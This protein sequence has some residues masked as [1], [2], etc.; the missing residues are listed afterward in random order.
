[1]PVLRPLP[2]S[3][4]TDERCVREVARWE[5]ILCPCLAS[6]ALINASYH[7]S[8]SRRERQDCRRWRPASARGRH[9]FP[10]APG[11]EMSGL[12]D[13]SRARGTFLFPSVP[14]HSLW[15]Q[16]SAN[17][18]LGPHGLATASDS[19][20]HGFVNGFTGF[21]G[22][23]FCHVFGH[24]RNPGPLFSITSWLSSSKQPLVFVLHFRGHRSAPS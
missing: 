11:A 17:V 24:W 9:F 15:H 23:S 4:S 5:K 18:R 22:G 19:T 1:M 21:A 2:S 6:P 14:S 16:Y 10:S 20:P 13:A 3:L 7:N 12:A 8:N